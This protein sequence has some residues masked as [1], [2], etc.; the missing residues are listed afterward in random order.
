MKVKVLLARSVIAIP[1]NGYQRALW[2]CRGY[3]GYSEV[4]VLN[5]VNALDPWW[6]FE[7]V[8]VRWWNFGSIPICSSRADAGDSQ[9]GGGSEGHSRRRIAL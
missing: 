2:S 4:S 7:R 6:A 3:E 1:A 8:V 9:S 5:L